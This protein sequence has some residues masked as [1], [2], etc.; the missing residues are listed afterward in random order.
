M[1][2]EAV[3]PAARL[4]QDC[5][6]VVVEETT[7]PAE[8]LAIDP[9]EAE[10]VAGAVLRRRVEY[11]AGR[12]CARR[13]LRRLGLPP[14][15]VRTAPDRSPQWPVAVVGSITHTGDAPGGYCGVAVARAS[16]VRALGIDAEESTPLEASLW[17]T[18]LTE[19]ERANLMARTGVDGAVDVGIVAKILFSAKECFYKAQFPLSRRFLDF[20]D[21]EVALVGDDGG[22]VA[23]I[24]S[25][26]SGELP[27][28]SG[29]GKF[30]LSGTLIVTGLIVPP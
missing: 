14:L 2:P 13:A 18:V 5:R 25:R 9:V 11:S 19:G 29:R 16:E 30:L 21:V 23:Q 6:A 3:G 7:L 4:F 24:V 12:W 10:H 28:H 8:P 26:V 17:P 22:F 20:R 27:L 1:D 15:A